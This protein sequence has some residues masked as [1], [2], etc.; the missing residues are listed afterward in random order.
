MDE[1]ENLVFEGDEH[2]TKVLASPVQSIDNFIDC[3]LAVE[4]REQ[5]DRC[6]SGMLVRT[7]TALCSALT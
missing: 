1:C 7:C 3:V 4:E 6:G 2:R 5:S